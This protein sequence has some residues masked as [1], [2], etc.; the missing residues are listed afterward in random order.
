[1]VS[2][3]KK[4]EE[5]DSLRGLMTELGINRAVQNTMKRLLDRC[6]EAEQERDRLQAV[7]SRP[8]AQEGNTGL[9]VADHGAEVSPRYEVR[10]CFGGETW[11][12][13]QDEAN[14]AVAEYEYAVYRDLSSRPVVPGGEG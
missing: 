2:M 5:W 8:G 3:D 6:Y 13:N 11:F 10:F 9:W 1:M 14:Q 12:E 4:A 7:L